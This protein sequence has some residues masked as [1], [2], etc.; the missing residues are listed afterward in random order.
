MDE[1]DFEV[2][3]RGFFFFHMLNHS[4][5]PN[6]A[7][8]TK[9]ADILIAIYLTFLPESR[10]R[11][12]LGRVYTQNLGFFSMTFPGFPPLF[13]ESLAALGFLPSQKAWAALGFLQKTC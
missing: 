12:Q 2:Q 3:F 10:F 5:K 9:K 13:P 4:T 1:P 11:T 7:F 6:S 8:T